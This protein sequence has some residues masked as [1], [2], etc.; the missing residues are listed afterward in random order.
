MKS[1][2]L[3]LPYNTRTRPS[4]HD[5]HSCHMHTDSR[6]GPHIHLQEAQMRHKNKLLKLENQVAERRKKMERRMKNDRAKLEE[7]ELELLE[8]LTHAHNYSSN[9]IETYDANDDM[10]AMT[11]PP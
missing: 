2:Q 3:Q 4:T 6:A 11:S 1:A 8:K 5:S 10:V 9:A 7:A